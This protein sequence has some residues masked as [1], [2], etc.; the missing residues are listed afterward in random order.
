MITA[1]EVMPLLLAACPSFAPT[2]ERIG[3]DDVDDGLPYA[4]AGDFIRHLVGLVLAERTDPSPTQ[5]F[6]S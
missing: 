2:W 4:H 6:R 3:S 1:D 5:T